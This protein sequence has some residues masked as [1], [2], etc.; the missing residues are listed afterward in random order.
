[1]SENTEKK[2]CAACKAYLF[3]DDDTVYCP[4]C[5]APH[6]RDCYMSLGKCALDDLHG[7]EKQ[8]DKTLKN[9]AQAKP[10]KEEIKVAYHTEKKQEE[11]SDYVECGMCSEKYDKERHS[12]PNCG[13]PNLSRLSGSYSFFDFL[14]GVPADMDL[15]EGVTA[16]E[17]KNFVLSNT[18]RYIPKFASMTAGVKASWNWL[19]FLFPGAWFLGRKMYKSGILVS[20]LY[21]AFSLLLMPFAQVSYNLGLSEMSNVYQFMSQNISK[22]GLPVLIAA[23][24]GGV[25]NILLRIL[26]GVYA[27]YFY[28]KHTISTVS[29]IKK[30]S[31]DIETDIRKKGGVNIFALLI[32]LFLVDRLA[33]IIFY[34]IV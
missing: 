34:I 11:S 29:S 26:S 22:I 12:C 2:V 21:V 25:F 27:D 24:I 1:M 31:D 20:T 7:T 3:E 23:A 5:G 33:E 8:Y 17:A 9:D 18:H 16:N 32:G 28:R 19:A 6:H 10:E 30:E 14:G 4:V 13:A 15:G